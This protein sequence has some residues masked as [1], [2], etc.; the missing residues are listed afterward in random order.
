VIYVTTACKRPDLLLVWL[1][2]WS[3]NAACC[4]RYRV[5]SVEGYSPTIYE[6]P[7][8]QRQ[9]PRQSLAASPRQQPWH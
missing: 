6:Q 5:R 8:L 1:L 4:D 9:Q 3:G 7:Q 2:L